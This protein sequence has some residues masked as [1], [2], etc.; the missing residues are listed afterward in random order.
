MVSFLRLLGSQITKFKGT[1]IYSLSSPL[2]VVLCPVSGPRAVHTLRYNYSSAFSSRLLGCKLENPKAGGTRVFL[3]YLGLA[4]TF[5]SLWHLLESLGALTAAG[6]ECLEGV[7]GVGGIPWM[8]REDTS[9]KRG[10]WPEA[11]H[12]LCPQG[13]KLLPCP[14]G[15]CRPAGSHITTSP[16]AERTVPLL[17][18][19]KK[20]NPVISRKSP[21][22]RGTHFS[23]LGWWFFKGR[24]RGLSPESPSHFKKSQ[25]H[26]CR[27]LRP[28]IDTL[29]TP[30]P[31]REVTHLPGCWEVLA[32]R[33]KLG[34]SPQQRIPGY[35]GRA[36]PALRDRHARAG[37]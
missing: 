30:S 12:C 4:H 11:R 35:P 6:P 32:L 36:P 20:E 25:I 19:V 5:C 2:S 22:G 7:W 33:E 9:R 31:Q 15:L 3:G 23:C 10:L 27:F 29:W 24:S 28:S 13:R 37:L 17:P 34:V 16:G 21:N 26:P 18:A 14:G 1:V 8:G